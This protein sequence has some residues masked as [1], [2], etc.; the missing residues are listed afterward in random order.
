MTDPILESILSRGIYQPIGRPVILK[1]QTG[2]TVTDDN[3]FD[4]Q[5]GK[6]KKRRRRRKLSPKQEN[7]L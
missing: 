5:A 7:T 2:Y 6:S 3:F 1:K 4:D